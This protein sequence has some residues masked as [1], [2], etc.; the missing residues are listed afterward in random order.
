MS[1]LEDLKALRELLA[2]PDSW[3]QGV[4][5]MDRWNEATFPLDEAATKFCLMG[6]IDCVTRTSYKRTS[7]IQCLF[8]GLIETPNIVGWNDKNGRKH[9]EV[10]KLIDKAIIAIED[11]NSRHAIY[12]FK[13]N[14]EFHHVIKEHDTP[15]LEITKEE[16]VFED[17]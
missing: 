14:E 12:D 15:P 8:M 10:L 11:Y 13:P 7:P 2:S 6:A 4:A 16:R 3:I 1:V 17:A 5:A 9:E